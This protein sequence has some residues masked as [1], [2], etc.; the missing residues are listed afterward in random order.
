M[1]HLLETLSVKQPQVLL[2]ALLGLLTAQQEA[3]FPELVYLKHVSLG[4]D[5]ETRES[6]FHIPSLV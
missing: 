4:K 5:N 1:S 2:K 6:F 3:V